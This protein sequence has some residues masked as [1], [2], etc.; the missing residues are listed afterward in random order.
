MNPEPD[1]IAVDLICRLTKAYSNRLWTYNKRECISVCSSCRNTKKF[2]EDSIHSEG[3]EG[4]ALIIEALTYAST[5]K[6]EV[7]IELIHKIT[8]SYYYALADLERNGVLV[9]QDSFDSIHR[10]QAWL[11]KYV[12]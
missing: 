11:K 8:S 9:G 7:P 2:G 10:L 6:S 12:D 5:G 3:C 4:V 1:P